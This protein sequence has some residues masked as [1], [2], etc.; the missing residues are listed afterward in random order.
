[1]TTLRVQHRHLRE[2]G[3]CNAGARR[4]CQRHGIDWR[5]LLTEGIP[6]DE[7]ERIDDA[8]AARVLQQARRDTRGQK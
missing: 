5:R 1:M 3:Y 7:V 6:A 8:M 2:L 4:F